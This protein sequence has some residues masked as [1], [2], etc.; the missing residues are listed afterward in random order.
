MNYQFLSQPRAVRRGEY[1]HFFPSV[2]AKWNLRRNLIA[3]AGYSYTISR[4]PLTAISG[5]WVINE[6]AQLITAPNPELKPELSDNYMAR[7]AWY[8][9]PVGSLSVTLSQNEISNFRQTR[10]VAATEAGFV[11]D[12]AYA[13]FEFSAPF[14]VEG[15]RRFR[16]MEVAYSQ[17]LSFLPGPFRGLNVNTSYTRTYAN[18]RRPGTSPHRVTGSLGYS[19]GRFTFRLGAVWAD[20]ASWTST[21]TRWRRHYTTTDFSGGVRLTSR[22]SFFFQGR[23]IFNDSLRIFEGVSHERD[24]AVLQ[25]YENYG[26][27]WVFGFKGMF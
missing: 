17:A 15:S 24:R 5:T 20:D 19:H 11:D 7:L 14:N 25:T 4:P 1:D 9:E 3:Q 6:T 23:R 27:N 8:F 16:T 2:S 21:V 26:A 12:P 10:R 13:D 22:V 18:E